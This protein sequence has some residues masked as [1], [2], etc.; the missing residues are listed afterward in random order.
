M[1]GPEDIFLLAGVAEASLGYG[2]QVKLPLYAQAGIPGVWPVNLGE[3]R[4]EVYW[5]PLGGVH[6]K[7]REGG[8][9]DTLSPMAFPRISLRELLP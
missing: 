2:R 3:I 6:Q 5:N 1:V 8:P 7:M 9:E 4:V